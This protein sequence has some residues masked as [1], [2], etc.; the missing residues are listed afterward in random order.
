MLLWETCIKE[1][2]S[3]AIN[4]VKDQISLAILIRLFE[5]LSI[6]IELIASLSF[7]ERKAG[8]TYY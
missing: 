6:Y 8:F 4:N 7:R 5:G 1:T 3:V 2:V